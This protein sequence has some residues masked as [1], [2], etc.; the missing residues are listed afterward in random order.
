MQAEGAERMTG[1]YDPPAGPRPPW[2]PPGEPRGGQANGQPPYDEPPYG[3]PPYGQPPYRQPPYGQP[4]YR[5]PPYGQPRSGQPAYGQP[6]YGEPYGGSTYGGQPYGQQPYGTQQPYGWPG[7]GGPGGPGGR[8][9]PYGYGGG[10]P[11]GP[12]GRLRR[13]LLALVAVVVIAV[14]SF[15]GLESARS[16]PSSPVQSTS[17]IAAN[18][19][20]GL[21]DIVTTLGFQRAQAAGTGMV[22]TSSGEILTNNHV[23]EGATSIR[24]TD[25]GNGQTYRAKVVGYDRSHDVAVLQLQGASGLETVSTANSGTASLGQ[26]VVALGNAG[27]KGGTPS[28]V[29]GRIIRLGASV[30]ATDA[31]AGTS[32]RLHGLIGHNAP[33]RP[34]DSGGPL[35]TRSGKVIGMNTAAST[36]S[37]F[38][39]QGRTQAFAIPINQALSVASKIEAKKSSATVHI[40]A[41]AFLGVGVLSAQQAQTRGVQPGAGVMIGDVFAGTAASGAGLRAGDVIVAAGGQR[42]GSPL[43]LQSVF[44][45]HHP[46]D[47]VG[48]SWLDSSGQRHSASVV[49]RSGPAG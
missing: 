27:G 7:P 1:I 18:V 6:S 42:V 47:R 11:G 49:L 20:D 17:T 3:Q 39:L 13:Q 36:G 10:R 43:A 40:G 25:I 24:A 23:I 35:V 38:Q 21:V 34:G 2:A 4:P 48:I 16:H 32:E 37:N 31:S 41:T 12:F 14:A 9:D 30:T 46:G 19:D 26:R 45:R 44:Q 15:F 29:T 8:Y 22:L 28:V 33:I 5:Q